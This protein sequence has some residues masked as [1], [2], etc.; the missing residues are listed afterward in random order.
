MQRPSIKTRPTVKT[1]QNKFRSLCRERKV[2][3]AANKLAS[4]NVEEVSANNRL[5]GELLLEAEEESKRK[6]MEQLKKDGYETALVSADEETRKTAPI[7]NVKRT[8]SKMETGKGRSLESTPEKPHWEDESMETWHMVKFELDTRKEC[9]EK[10]LALSAQELPPEK[11]CY[12]EKIE[13]HEQRKS[14]QRAQ[15]QLQNAL[16]NESI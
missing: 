11:E 15:L 1:L 5:R 10:S 9:K 14:K 7:E 8:M 13:E 12:H 4:R 2:A 16:V 3:E 6:Q